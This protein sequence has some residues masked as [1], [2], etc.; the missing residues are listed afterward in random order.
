MVAS[1]KGYTVGHQRRLKVVER[2]YKKQ[3][4]DD[5]FGWGLPQELPPKK[6]QS[7]ERLY[8]L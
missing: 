4:G 5:L 3:G 8:V 2:Y 1:N 7:I 6:S